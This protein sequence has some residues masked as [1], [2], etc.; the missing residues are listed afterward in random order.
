MSRSTV[1][2]SLLSALVLGGLLGVGDNAARAAAQHKIAMFG[3]SYG[4]ASVD[5]RVGDTIVFTNDDVETHWVYVPTV[6]FQ[7][8]RANIK[9]GEIFDLRVMRPGK[10]LVLCAVH[11]TMAATVRV[12][13]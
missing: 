1:T 11:N 2:L 6:D 10:F 4:P 7:I 12:V 3:T 9:P 5:A 8:S 13:P